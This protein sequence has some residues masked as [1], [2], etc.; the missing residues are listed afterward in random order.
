MRRYIVRDVELILGSP[1]CGKT[2]KLLNIVDSAL[3]A[4]ILPDEIAFSSFTR[5]AANE[6]ATRACNKFGFERKELPYFRTLH[7]TAFRSLGLNKHDIITDYS[8]IADTVGIPLS[9]SPDATTFL[10]S[11]TGRYQEIPFLEALARN[12]LCSLQDQWHDWQAENPNEF[13]DWHI[14]ELYARTLKSYKQDMG[15]YDYT[16]ILQRF[17]TEGC[18]LP[19]KL[20]IIDEAQDLSKLQWEMIACAGRAASKVIIAGDDDQSIFEW[21][22]AD[23]N[24]FLNLEGKK[25]VLQYSHRLPRSVFNVAHNVA[26]RIRNRYAKIWY[27]RNEEGEVLQV[28]ALDQVDIIPGERYMFLARNHYFL[29]EAI[30]YIRTAGYFYALNN[31]PHS[32]KTEYLTAIQYW[33]RLRKNE[34]LPVEQV[35]LIYDYIRPN[36]GITPAAKKSL[37]RLPD[38]TQLSINELLDKHGLRCSSLWHNSL[39]GIPLEEREYILLCLRNGEKITEAPRIYIGTVHSVKGGEAENVI[40]IPD[41]SRLSW[42]SYQHNEDAENRVLYVALTRS[43][44]RL[45]TVFPQTSRHYYL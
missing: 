30:E 20:L 26:S 35:Q 28:N 29:N 44:K 33:E 23:I 6:A 24:T 11:G 27:P 5:K 38:N 43:I 40:F 21:A 13:I 42:K 16:D 17:I 37:A 15:L 31:N 41:L 8:E 18:V 4:G 9:I 25:E 19:V 45:I 39:T 32:V 34:R 3:Q 7:S 10:P 1:G 2:T 36:H 12:R 14:I 22:G